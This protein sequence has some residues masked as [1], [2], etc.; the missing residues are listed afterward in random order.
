VVDCYH[1]GAGVLTFPH[2]CHD[3]PMHY[4]AENSPY[5]D[6]KTHY[7]ADM[8][9]VYRFYQKY[10][11]LPTIYPGQ[12]A[13]DTLRDVFIDTNRDAFFGAARKDFYGKMARTWLDSRPPMG[14]RPVRAGGI[15]RGTY[16]LSAAGGSALQAVYTSRQVH[17][18]FTIEKL[19]GRG[20]LRN[21]DLV[22]VKN[23]QGYYLTTCNSTGVVTASATSVGTCEKFYIRKTNDGGVGPIAHGDSFGLQALS[24]SRYLR[25]PPGGNADVTATSIQSYE[26]MMLE[27]TNYETADCGC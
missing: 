5:P 8:F 13:F 26:T 16:Y 7:R 19:S 14:A 9:P 4:E 20:A 3:P 2:A 17:G 12:F 21:Y 1:V 23:Y 11:L 15:K 25:I 6:G 24:N 22:A 18:T 10:G 27:R